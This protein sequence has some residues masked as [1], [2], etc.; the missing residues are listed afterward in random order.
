MKTQHEDHTFNQETRNKL[1]V[2]NATQK[3]IT[4]QRQHEERHLKII[5]TK[6]KVIY[7]SNI[8]QQI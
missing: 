3:I 6:M 7:L 5:E 8:I 2:Q 4:E 1:N